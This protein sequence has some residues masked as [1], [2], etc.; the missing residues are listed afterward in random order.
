MQDLREWLPVIIVAAGIVAMFV[1]VQQGQALTASRLDRLDE[2]LDRHT[3]SSA[4]RVGEIE[5]MLTEVVTRQRDVERL[6]REIMELKRRL[7]RAAEHIAALRTHVS[8][9]RGSDPGPVKSRD[10]DG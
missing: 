8:D 3:S 6:E 2:K 1:R 7:D 9:D 5:R 4:A 10:S